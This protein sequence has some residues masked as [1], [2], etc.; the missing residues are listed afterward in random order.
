MI[1]KLNETKYS[2]D[3]ETFNL[4]KALLTT[5]LRLNNLSAFRSAFNFGVRTKL[6][7]K[8]IEE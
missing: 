4:L 8:I 5:A 6:I 1:F 3:R 2:T 7:N